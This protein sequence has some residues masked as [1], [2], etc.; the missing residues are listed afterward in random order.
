[1]FYRHTVYHRKKN[2]MAPV[3]GTTKLPLWCKRDS[4]IVKIH[5][6]DKTLF[7]KTL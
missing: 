7:Y 3:V 1:M 5:K 4:M 6:N 2:H